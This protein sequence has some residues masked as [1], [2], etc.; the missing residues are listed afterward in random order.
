M[1]LQK[2]LLLLCLTFFGQNNFSYAANSKWI[3]APEDAAQVRLIASF[4]KNN[5]GEK[6][7]I[8][9]LHFKLK[10]GWKIYGQGADSFGLPP[11]LDFK[12]SQNYQNHNIVW[13]KPQ[14]AR[15]VIGEDS[16]E[17]YY[18][19]N[20]VILPIEINLSNYQK[21][22]LKLKFDYG[23]CKDVCIP[24]SHELLVELS[25][26]EDVDALVE[27]QKFY[28]TKIAEIKSKM[29]AK[30]IIYMAL[31]ALIGGAILNI[32]PCVLP[33]LSIKLISIINHLDAKVSRIRFAF[34]STILGILFCFLILA[35][36]A[37]ALK[38][39]GHAFGWGFQFQNNYFLIFLIIV[40][41]IFAAN[42]LGVFEINFDRFFVNT[43]NK[44]IDE[45]SGKRKNFIAN[46]LSGILAVLLA[47]PCSAPFLGSAIS[48]ALTQNFSTIFII[49]LLIGIGFSLPYF[50]LLINPRIVYLLPKPGNWMLKVKKL[51][52]FFLILTITWL[53]YTLIDQNKSN[54][55]DGWQEFNEE[56]IASLVAEGKTVIVDITA[57]WCIT[58]KFNK[59]RVLNDAEVLNKLNSSYIVKMRGDITKPNEKIMN[60]LHKNN[61]FAIPFNAIYGPNAK[62]GLLT[63]ELLNKKDLLELINQ[64]S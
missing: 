50:I 61:R 21:G 41:A 43:I 13:P 3:K 58:C 62:N 59:A 63:S 48:F 8:A 46:F 19:K 14:I 20:E 64:A 6:K 12:E 33:V 39:A 54:N 16:F 2:I 9:G 27:I 15:E 22:E 26:K 24:A 31:F 51:M 55:N 4:Y 37:F 45:A 49:F 40:L 17:Y 1:K 5:D 52:A 47:T 29:P 57:D 60:F 11:I 28:P 32:M 56:E 44:K 34:L 42:L 35:S 10:D 30:G 23:L 7:L 18:Y 53:G 38:F 36:I 25:N